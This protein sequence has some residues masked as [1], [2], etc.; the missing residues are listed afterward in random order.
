MSAIKGIN[1]FKKSQDLKVK[2][3]TK[4]IMRIFFNTMAILSVGLNDIK[5]M[6]KE[7]KKLVCKIE[8]F[9]NYKVTQDIKII[10]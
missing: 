3:N 6:P 7:L 9:E 10:N 2:A 4:K 5:G 1:N 8:E